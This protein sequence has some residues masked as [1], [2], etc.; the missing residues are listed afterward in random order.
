MTSLVQNLT[1]CTDMKSGLSKKLVIE[2]SL[3][4]K[5]L[6]KRSKLPTFMCPTCVPICMIGIN[7]MK[8]GVD[9][10]IKKHFYSLRLW[11]HV[12]KVR[13]QSEQI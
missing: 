5:T 9:L 6:K 2:N 3:V 8:N 1:Q 10:K 11:G 13:S 4:H 12:P 7:G